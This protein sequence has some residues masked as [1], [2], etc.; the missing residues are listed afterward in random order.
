MERTSVGARRPFII[1]RPA[2]TPSLPTAPRGRP[3]R[4]PIPDITSGARGGALALAI[5]IAI[6]HAYSASGIR[7]NRP[8]L[9]GTVPISTAKSRRPALLTPCPAFIDHPVLGGTSRF[10]V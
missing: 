4:V 10:Q 7:V 3:D 6:V 9:G 1:P 8:A 5:I 2:L